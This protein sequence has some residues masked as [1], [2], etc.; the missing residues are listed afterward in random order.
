MS[1]LPWHAAPSGLSH[2]VQLREETWERSW[3]QPG[4]WGQLGSPRAE[5]SAAVG[6]H[7]PKRNIRRLFRRCV[8]TQTDVAEV[9][10][11]GGIQQG[12]PWGANI[13]EASS[14]L[15]QASPFS[16]LSS[17][18]VLPRA[19]TCAEPAWPRARPEGAGEHKMVSARKKRGPK[20][21]FQQ[22][23]QCCMLPPRHLP[24]EVSLP[25][26]LGTGQ[27]C[28]GESSLG[29]GWGAAACRRGLQTLPCHRSQ[30]PGKESK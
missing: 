17:N 19:A 12:S 28:K 27:G 23:W 15:Q 13:R 24:W 10:A 20:Q 5:Q 16:K 29:D 6:D 8:L 7:P 26:A 11:Q 14:R 2:G 22:Q 3:S 25:S 4:P 30:A 18:G 21:V 1:V 9:S